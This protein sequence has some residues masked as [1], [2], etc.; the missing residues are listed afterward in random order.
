MIT[1]G[2]V[3]EK[4]GLNFDFTDFDL[5]FFNAANNLI[6][7]IAAKAVKAGMDAVLID[8][9]EI[10]PKVPHETG[11]LRAT[12]T[13]HQVEVTPDLITGQ[14]SFGNPKGGQGGAPYALRWH[15]V[16]PGTVHFKEPGT[17][18]K[19]LESKLVRFKD[20]YIEIMGMYIRNR[21]PT[22]GR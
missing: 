15:E 16:E 5:G 11:H 13:V 14:I 9:I 6:P 1:T 22:T 4:S 19:Y 3:D 20:K 21:W 17:G 10:E 2:P 7:G 18:P 8:A 12:G